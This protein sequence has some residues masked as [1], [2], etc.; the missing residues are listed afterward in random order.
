MDFFS[1]WSAEYLNQCQPVRGAGPG[2]LSFL[3]GGCTRTWITA[4]PQGNAGIKQNSLLDFSGCGFAQHLHHSGIRK[5][6][7]FFFFFGLFSAR[8]GLFP[9]EG[10]DNQDCHSSLEIFH[11]SLLGCHSPSQFLGI[12][13]IFWEE[14]LNSGKLW[15]SLS[16]E[17]VKPW[18]PTSPI[19]QTLKKIP[20]NPKLN[21]ATQSR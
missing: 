8:L 18:C 4:F 1:L 13:L 9:L 21:L 14:I 10:R 15:R 11:P 19:N 16:R 2:A 6:E 20:Q 12:F 3:S 17:G 5:A 7:F